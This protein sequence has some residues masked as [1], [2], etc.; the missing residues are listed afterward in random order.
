MIKPSYIRTCTHTADLQRPQVLV[1]DV[2]PRP[3]VHE[4]AHPRK[5]R[6]TQQT[7]AQARQGVGV[8]GEGRITGEE[9]PKE[10]EK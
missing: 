5:A 9:S 10:G 3:A 4:A 6:E 2:P 8:P 1:A 7:G